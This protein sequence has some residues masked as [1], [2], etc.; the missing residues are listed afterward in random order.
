[1]LFHRLKDSFVRKSGHKKCDEAELSPG[2]G[3]RDIKKT[4]KD[5][6]K[7]KNYFYAE[8]LARADLAIEAS[9][10]QQFHN[11]CWFA[12]DLPKV[13]YCFSFVVWTL[14]PFC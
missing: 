12:K 14:W 8:V 7:R 4:E 3:L 6:K 2:R 9:D 10:V 13:G 5:R 1:M 11:I